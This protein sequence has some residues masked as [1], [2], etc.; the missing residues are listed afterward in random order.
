MS[1]SQIA[2]QENVITD[3]TVSVDGINTIFSADLDGDGDM[4][5]LSASSNDNKIAWYE[6]VDGQGYFGLQKVISIGVSGASFVS[7]T[8]FDG[9][10]DLDV[11]SNSNYDY[12]IVWFENTDG[13]GAFGEEQV[14][15]T[16]A[17]SVNSLVMVD[18]DGDGDMDILSPDSDGNGIIWYEN[19]DGLG[20]FG[21]QHSIATNVGHINIINSVDMDGDGDMD[22]VYLS[23]RLAWQE[24]TDGLGNLGPQINISTV[25]NAQSLY[26][27]DLDNDGDMDVLTSI[28]YDKIAWYENM[29]GQGTF[30]ELQ[31][32]SSNALGANNAYARDVDGDGDMDVISSSSGDDKVAW[33]E[34]TDGNGNF[35][36]EQLITENAHFVLSIY[37]TDL[38]G[39]GD[40][41]VISSSSEDDKI[42]W[43]E[44]TDGLG[45][46]A[47]EHPIISNPGYNQCVYAADLD[48]DGDL[49]VLTASSSTYG[50]I[51]WYEN[52]NGLGAYGPQKIITTDSYNPSSVF[53]TDID[54]DGDM[55]V[56]SA[57][58][59]T[60]SCTGKIAWYENTDGQG[61]F[62]PPQIIIIGCNRPTSIYAADLDGDNDMDIVATLSNDNHLAWFE[63]TDGQGN[64]GPLENILYSVDN[65]KSVN[66]AD[67]DGDG[68]MDILSAS[69]DD[70]KIAWYEN[71]DG[72]GDFGPQQIITTSADGANSVYSMDL[73][74]DGDND[75]LS[76]SRGD[77]KIAWY[78]NID[79]EGTFGPQQII[80]T[81]A[82][83]AVSV[84]A[85]DLDGDGDNDVISASG[86]TYGTIAWYENIDGQGDFGTQ[87]I[88]TANLSRA[89]YV[90][91]DDIDNDGDFDIL[92]TS[93]YYDTQVIWYKNLG[94]QS[95]EINGIVN[96]DIDN[97]GCD[98]SYIPAYN[99]LIN[100]TDGTNNHSSFTL[101]NG[102]YQLFPGQG[103][104]TTQITNLPNYYTSNPIAHTSNFT[105]TGNTDTAS[106]CIQPIGS[107]NDLNIAIYPSLNDPR[108]GFNTTYQLVYSNGGT[109]QSNGNINFGFD[110][111][112]LQFLNAS[113]IVSSQTSNALTFEFTD[114]KPFETRT[115][116]LNFNVFAPPTTNIDDILSSMVTINPILAD[117]TQEDNVFT[118][119]QIVIGS[120]DPNDITVLEGA[121]ILIED[122]DNYLHYLIRFQNTGTASAINVLVENTLDDKLDWTTM[123]L[124]SLSHTAKVEIMNGSEVSF[125]FDNI[126]LP[127]STNNEPNSH[128]YI[129]YKIKPKDNVVLGDIFE[130]TADIFFD[131]NPAI[132][133][134]TVST[135]IVETLSVL[136]NNLEYVLIHPNPTNTTLY[137][138]ANNKLTS[139]EI[140]NLL[141]QQMF[142]NKSNALTEEIDMSRFTAGMYL[143]KVTIGERASIYKVIKE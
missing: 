21:V 33:Y 106:F 130:N 77:N 82:E 93:E 143:V 124:E 65:P 1:F 96:I 60:G 71:T 113:Q 134:N 116:D 101:N 66:V 17:H 36:M 125:I 94:N 34:N 123:Q 139:V 83:N 49:D 119:Q 14:V 54:G 24:N 115:I 140:Y 97:N 98:N 87:Q 128:G 10:G 2:F 35:G 142:S 138:E 27:S 67:V 84:F 127:D 68:D 70:D 75:V 28:Y 72:Q 120:Y 52:T 39:D 15:A 137:I 114:L 80:T 64:F 111:T 11:V 92:C 9:D 26:A 105:N 79:G 73:D 41:D 107:V 3:R 89:T 22:V 5:I 59:G 18:F 112:K 7:A 43:H 135:E 132:T 109:S 56:I 104:F 53:T 78:E 118:L 4:D 63:N 6:N 76:A 131:Y 19:T 91:A 121:Q 44:N 90:Y 62:G 42:V 85:I 126:Y 122:A 37:P 40:M 69:Y 32:I 99:F 81:N 61:T 95:N 8:D 102:F 88:I 117:E 74:G 47:I 55:D 48:G 136:E 50:N 100:T 141:G 57:S 86:Y 110:N 30:G 23:D 25:N 38:D 45:S 51:A 108:P 12:K 29:D 31:I 133:T 58:F 16:D 129:A 13:L 103:E 46:F 20:T